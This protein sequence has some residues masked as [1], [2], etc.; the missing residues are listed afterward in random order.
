VRRR[1]PLAVAAV[2][3][4]AVA[5]AG[6][7]DHVQ[8]TVNAHGQ[9]GW[10]SYAIA[11]M[12]EVSVALAVLKVRRARGTG[13]ATGWA[14]LVGVS[15]AAFTVSA[16]LA[17]AEH[18]AWGYVVAAWPAWASIGAFGLIEVGGPAQEP[19][20]ARDD[21][22]E[23]RVDAILG[24]VP[25]PRC[26]HGAPEGFC[27]DPVHYP[28][29][30]AAQQL[31]EPSQD[32][33]ELGGALESDP[34]SLAAANARTGELLVEALA[35]MASGPPPGAD[36]RPVSAARLERG[37]TVTLPAGDG[38][39]DVDPLLTAAAQVAADLTAGG[40]RVTRAALLDGLRDRRHS[41][42]TARG[43]ELLAQLRAIGSA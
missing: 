17:T 32:L 23:A 31:Q 39:D 16:N 30:V 29:P 9:R 5:F 34:E 25:D 20:P 38:G 37:V 18:S 42:S 10:L 4:A 22:L 40:R 36:P 41:C 13:E 33:P 12:P 7:F 14:W 11:S 15:A 43:S 1:D 21:E 28:E 35:L 24:S 19:V 27:A 8:A 26:E 3:L 2:A 6:S